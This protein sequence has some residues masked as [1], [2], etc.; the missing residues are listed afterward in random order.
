MTDFKALG[1]KWCDAE[2]EY[3]KARREL[4][5]QIEAVML[6]KANV[7]EINAEITKALECKF[8]E[9]RENYDPRK[10]CSLRY[11]KLPEKVVVKYRII[12]A[13]KALALI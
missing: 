11:A 13:H 5:E 10:Y 2:I 1:Q 12:E 7:R 9:Y 3:A 6:L 8:P 4:Q